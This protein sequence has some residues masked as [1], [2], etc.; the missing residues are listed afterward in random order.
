MIQTMTSEDL[1]TVEQ[2]ARRLSVTP[3][4][5]REWLRAGKLKG[6]KI[7]PTKAGWRVR[8]ADLDAFVEAG[9]PEEQPS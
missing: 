8:G 5:V 7:G 3:Y 9:R 1:L 4:T 2:V 6:Y